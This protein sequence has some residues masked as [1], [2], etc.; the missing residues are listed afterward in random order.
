MEYLKHAS[1]YNLHQPHLN[2]LCVLSMEYGLLTMTAKLEG[3]TKQLEEVKWIP[4]RVAASQEYQHNH[5][6][7]MADRMSHKNRY[8]QTV[9]SNAMLPNTKLVTEDK[10][11]VD[12]R[13]K[14][15]D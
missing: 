2:D 3:K 12:L 10:N 8:H 4:S 1:Q 6:K 5:T 11:S 7:Q 15:Q 14:V 9:T 13:Q